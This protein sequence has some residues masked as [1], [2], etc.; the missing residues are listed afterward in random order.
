MG[1]VS[2]ITQGVECIRCKTMLTD[3]AS[4]RRGYGEDCQR[5]MNDAAQEVAKIFSRTQVHKA[6]TA[7]R[8]GAVRWYSAGDVTTGSVYRV[9]SSNG[10]DVYYTTRETCTCPASGLCYH[11]CAVMIRELTPLQRH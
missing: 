10:R 5:I 1:S 11:R 6:A 7:L 2:S 4:I 9:E 3:P 8:N